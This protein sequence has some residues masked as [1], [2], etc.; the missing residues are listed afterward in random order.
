MRA[1]HPWECRRK[2]KRSLNVAD[3]VLLGIAAE[4]PWNFPVRAHW[5]MQEKEKFQSIEVNLSN[6]TSYAYCRRKSKRHL[7]QLS[8]DHLR[9]VARAI[10]I[11]AGSCSGILPPAWAMSCAAAAAA[12]HRLSDWPH[13]I[14]RMG[15]SSCRSPSPPPPKLP[16]QPP[17]LLASRTALGLPST[18]LIDQLPHQV[19]VAVGASAIDDRHI[20]DGLGLLPIACPPSGDRP[21]PSLKSL[22]RL[23]TSCKIASIRSGTLNAGTDRSL[24]I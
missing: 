9:I 7:P 13:P 2:L 18:D 5:L 4:G 22:F 24:A 17:A 1:G 20:A 23:S 21:T 14:A 6:R 8:L 12:S 11:A 3:A 15:A 19:V 16:W 10:S